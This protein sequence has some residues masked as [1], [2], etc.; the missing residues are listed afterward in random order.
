MTAR[1]SSDAGGRRALAVAALLAT[2]M[3]ALNISLPNAAALHMQGTLSMSDDEVGWVFTSYIAASLVVTPVT[4]WLA[5]RFGRK[6]VFLWSVA[7][8]AFA[9][10]LDTRAETPLQFVLAR[11]MQGAASAPLAPLSLAMLLDGAPPARQPRINLVWTTILVLGIVSGP[12][13]GGWVGEYF[14]WRSIFY[15]SLPA[16]AFVFLATALSLPEKK[17]PETPPLDVF[18]LTTFSLGLL[19][20]QAMLDR[21]ERMEWFA[22]PEIWIEAA[23]SVTGFYLFLVHI[24]SSKT[25]FISKGLFRDRNFVVSTVMFFAF[26]FVLLPTMALTSP[27]L[28]ELFGYPVDTTGYMTIPRGLALVLA[29]VLTSLALPRIDSRLFVACGAALVIWANG[30]MLGYSPGMDWRFVAAAGLVQGAGLGMLMPA[31]THTAFST[32]APTLRPEGAML[33]NLAR[34]YGSTIGIAVVQIFFFGNTQAA[35]LAL[36]KQLVPYR[37]AAHL[38]GT[39]PPQALA[40]LNEMVTGQAAVIAVIGQFKI[41]MIAM[42]AASPLVL[43]LRKPRPAV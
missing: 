29:L 12:A 26:G 22:S 30:R 43:L 31:L 41:L 4:R 27:M 42:L 40:G 1:L 11:V 2:F 35:H 38:G 36:A 18:G 10:V 24:L 6:A 17:A 8:F 20:L 33:F 23:L 34:L 37:A 39:L 3:Q 5:A 14:G 21:G 25:H 13:L 9:L 16:A 7:I 19:G 15:L 28:E 32:L